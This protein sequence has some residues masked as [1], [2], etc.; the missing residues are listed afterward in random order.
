MTGRI[1]LTLLVVIPAAMAY[2]WQ[3]TLDWWLVGIA[4]AVAIVVFAWW[5]GT[6]VTTLAARR[7]ALLRH[8]DEPRHQVQHS[9][10]DAY[11]TVVLQVHSR[12]DDNLMLATL[13]GYLDRYGIRSESVR[14]T[15]RDTPSGCATWVGLTFSAATNLTALQ[16]RSKSIPLR[17][18][19][20]ITLR[21]LADHLRELGWSVSA[22]DVVIPDVVGPELTERWKAVQDGD[23]GYLT[24]YAVTTDGDFAATLSDI[25]VAASTEVWTAVELTGSPARPAVAAVCAIR[26]DEVPSAVPLPALRPL[27]GRQRIALAALHPETT[28]RLIVRT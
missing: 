16:A 13:A 21:R 22:A 3:T 2:P 9:G 17:E 18:T 6:F 10:T 26:T 1:M 20:E 8:T 19:A 4:V 7:L 24:C 27:R 5:R 12:H 14:V 28:E 15:H 11:T 23:H 25:R